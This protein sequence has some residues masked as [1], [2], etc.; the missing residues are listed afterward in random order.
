[1]NHLLE[2]VLSIFTFIQAAVLITSKNIFKSLIFSN[3]QV[4][5][6]LLLFINHYIR[7]IKYI[8]IYDHDYKMI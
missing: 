4:H 5:I 3:E 1:M 2:L 8:N 6:V 7:H